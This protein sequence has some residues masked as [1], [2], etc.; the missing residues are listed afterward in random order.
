MIVTAVSSWILNSVRFLH[1]CSFYYFTS[2]KGY[3]R[4]GAVLVAMHEWTKAQRAYEDALHIDPSNNE[5]REG[6][7]NCLRSNDESPEKVHSFISSFTI[8]KL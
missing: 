7:R 6:L 5:A 4:K 8:V 3:T 2:V 1:I